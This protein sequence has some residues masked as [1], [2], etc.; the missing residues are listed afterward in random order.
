VSCE[1]NTLEAYQAYLKGN[2]LKRHLEKAKACL[3]ALEKE[4]QTQLRREAERKQKAE[5]QEQAERKTTT[6]KFFQFEELI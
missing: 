2:T 3:Q 4:K 1:Q 6:D 5:Q